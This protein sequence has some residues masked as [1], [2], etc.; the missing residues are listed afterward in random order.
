M[1]SMRKRFERIVKKCTDL[2][3]AFE[4]DE[5]KF[6]LGLIDIEE[7]EMDCLRANG[8]PTFESYIR[9]YS[10]CDVPRYVEFRKGLQTIDRKQAESIGAPAVIALA[11]LVNPS[12]VQE[13]VRAVENY[14]IAH[15]GLRPR[16][17]WARKLLRQVD[18]RREEP[19]GTRHVNQLSR[20]LAE[21]EQLRAE[22]NAARKRIK[23]LEKQ[24]ERTKR[25][26]PPPK[27]TSPGAAATQ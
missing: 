10:F 23:D 22:L 18:P 14:A 25:K 15:D 20:V 26:G 4:R 13:Y 24:L 7:T 27:G 17:Q 3:A 8:M 11:N 12:A 9:S 6:F 19:A 2:R 1:E 5:A 21:N 16:D